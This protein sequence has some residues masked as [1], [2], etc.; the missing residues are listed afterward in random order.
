MK[1]TLVAIAA[2]MA[3]ALSGCAAPQSYADAKDMA[4]VFKESETHYLRLA[5]TPCVDEQVVARIKPKFR[6]DFRAGE[7]VSGEYRMQ[8]CYDATDMTQ[9]VLIVTPFDGSDIR[10]PMGLFTLESRT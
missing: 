9:G 6:S 8:V 7:F 1:K 4:W 5:N 2:L 10:L 3:L